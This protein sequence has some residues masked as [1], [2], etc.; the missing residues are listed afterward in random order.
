MPRSFPDTALSDEALDWIIRLHAG[1]ATEADWQAWA[2]WRAQ[3]D[4]FDAAAREAEALWHGL[5][6]AGHQ[7]K[8]GALTRRA[9]LG[10]GAAVVLGAGL[11]Q[12]GALLP[13]Y[14]TMAAERRNIVLADG[15]A[16]ALNAR[17]A[18]NLD[19]RGVAMLRGQATFDAARDLLLTV[20]G[21]EVH[22]AAARFDVD[23]LAG[24]L[25]LTCLEGAVTLH[26]GGRSARLQGGERLFT[27]GWQRARVNPADALAW[28]RGKLILDQRPLAELV[29]SLERYRRGRIV[30][31][32]DQV[33]DLRVSGVFNMADGDLILQSLAGPLPIT[34]TQLPMFS[35]IRRA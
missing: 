29:A 12:T 19:A 32:G 33:A 24:G 17:T 10:G 25:A 13:D 7:V 8:R 21:G 30:I 1:G 27:A 23:L 14:S 34:V 35:A 22:A 26:F 18:L 5:G 20:P 6:A 31:W 3:G 28:Q 16:V 2:L 11:L 9:V 15:T 4:M